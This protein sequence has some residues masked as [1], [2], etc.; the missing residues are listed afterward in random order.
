MSPTARAPQRGQVLPVALGATLL[1]ALLGAAL[2]PALGVVSADTSCVY[3]CTTSSPSTPLWAW[4]AIGIIV[5][6]A[7][8]STAFLLMRRNR[9]RPPAEPYNGPSEGAAG[10]AGAG[11]VAGA[12]EPEAPPATE[13]APNGNAAYIE[14]PEDT[15]APPAVLA[16]GA[17]AGAAAGAVAGAAADDT[18]I[19]ALMDELDKI[20]GEILK[21][22]Q[23]TKGSSS[24]EPEAK[25]ADSE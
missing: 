13:T 7:I 16:S 3:N 17:A 1:I 11:A 2:L 12:E 6:A 22:D 24:A 14:Q 23:R 18:N 8:L 10:V 9:S 5:V 21:K 25:D 15:A 19:D 20:S 4:A